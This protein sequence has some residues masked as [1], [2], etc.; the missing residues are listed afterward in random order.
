MGR[1]LFAGARRALHAPLATAKRLLSGDDLLRHGSLLAATTVLA[2]GLNYAFQIFMGRALGPEQYGVFG[3][4]FAIFYLVGVLGSGVQFSTSRFTAALDQ[5][6][7]ELAA[8]HAGLLLRSLLVG[9]AVCVLLLLASPALSDFLGLSS[10]WP[11]VLVAAIVPLDFAHRANKGSFQ[12]QEW[13]GLLGSYNVFDAGVKLLAGVALV[14]LGYGVFGALAALVVAVGIGV[15][16]TTVHVRRRLPAAALRLRDSDLSFRHVYAFAGPAVLAGFCVSVPA[17]VDVI[18][19]K[20]S[21]AGEQAGLYT[22]VTVLGKVL[23]YLPMGISTVLFPKVTNESVGDG[24]VQAQSLLNRALLYAGVVAGTGATAFWLF[25]RFL[26]DTLFGAAYA[27]AAPLLQWY[28]VAIFAVVLA[29]IILRFEL[30]RDRTRFVYVFAAVT[31]VEIGLMWLVSDTM[32]H[33]V[34]VIL[35]VNVGLLGYGIVRVKR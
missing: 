4:L 25:P 5:H 9:G 17:N 16:L 10:V 22:S 6:E 26:L 31:V 13:F 24:P 23:V 14:V 35:A 18:L 33:V 7:R 30:A 19:V 2:G 1:E 11:L 34:Q 20:H 8:R 28:G 29:I 27:P 15:V 3:A 12:G 21:V 32:L